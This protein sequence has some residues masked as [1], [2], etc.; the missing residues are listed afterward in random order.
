VAED[1]PALKKKAASVVARFIGQKSSIREAAVVARLTCAVL[2]YRAKALHEW[3][4]YDV[5]A[6]LFLI[7]RS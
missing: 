2:R 1:E 4:N 5:L 6:E 3:S 7:S